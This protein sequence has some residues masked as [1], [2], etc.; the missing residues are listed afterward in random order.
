MVENSF[1]ISGLGIGRGGERVLSGDIRVAGAKNA[2]LKIMAS[3]ALFDDHVELLNVPEI[4]DVNRMAELLEGVGMKI[5][6]SAGKR[7]IILPA[8][9]DP[10][11]PMGPAT[12]MRSSIVLTGPMLSRMGRVSFPNPGGC[13]LGNRPIDLFLDG[14]RRMGAEIRTEGD[15]YVALAPDG[16]QGMEF[17]FKVQSHT[18]TETLMMAATLAKGRTVLKNCALEPEVK[19]LADFLNACGAKISGAGTSTIIID[20]V[21]NLTSKGIVYKTMPDRIETGSFMI[22][23]ALA[24]RS[25]TIR[26]C[27]P[28]HVEIITEILRTA[29]VDVSVGESEITV[30]GASLSAV[31]VR[32]HEF[33]GLPTDLQAPM[34]V[35]LTQAEGESALFETIYEG[36]LAYT[37]DLV[38]MGA[39]I[40]S[41][42]THRVLIQG[43]TPLAGKRVKA[44][45]LRAGMA[46]V[47]AGIIASGETIVDNAYVIDRG[48][49]NIAERLTALGVD[50]KRE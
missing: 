31:N 32:T 34:G 5:E 10:D 24:G 37:K 25:I 43:P 4:E 26:D 30:K 2:A 20:G 18:G 12:A 6:K 35:L 33:P 21:R 9:L 48:Y 14:F 47:I 15:M 8:K 41:Q 23:A 22:L 46:F 27:I 16:L 1:R 3:A 19:S 28:G 11:L 44:P 50:I 17:F 39:K 29:G 49:E 13:S 45:D 38:A 40:A 7:R 42:D 36:R